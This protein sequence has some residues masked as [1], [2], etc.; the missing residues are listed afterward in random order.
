MKW[1]YRKAKCRRHRLS[2]AVI[3]LGIAGTLWF[4]LW[5]NIGRW[6]LPVQ[7]TA[8]P[9]AQ[10]DDPDPDD[11]DTNNNDT[12][13][14]DTD[15]G[16][17]TDNNSSD[18]GDDSTCNANTYEGGVI[19]VPLISQED[20]DMPTGCELVSAY[21]L[22]EY[23]GCSMSFDEWVAECV[24]TQE[25]WYE[26]G[27]L[28]NLSPWE[29]FIGMPYQDGGYGCYA[30]VICSAMQKA[31]PDCIVENVTGQTLEQLCTDYIEKGT[32][33]LVWATMSMVASA[34]GDVWQTP[35]GPFEWIANEHCLVLVGADSDSYFFNDPEDGYL[36]R[37]EKTLVEQRYAELGMQAVVVLKG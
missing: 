13:N 22:L 19:P 6:S 5:F 21:M 31:L 26:N 18:D 32:P 25:F 34:G 27:Q 1:K 3:L 33:V 29:A 23:Y 4:F 14:R 35:N 11:D 24:P 15:C 7:E 10:S 17:T 8:V 12:D 2:A 16:N 37:W 28:Y 36:V 20:L 9:P 30:P